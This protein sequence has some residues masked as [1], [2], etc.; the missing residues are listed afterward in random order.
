MATDSYDLVV[1]GGGVVGASLAYHAVAGGAR[2]LL[3]D[4]ADPGQASAAGAGIV[5]A[6]THRPEA[7]AWRDLARAATGYYPELIDALGGGEVTGF[8]LSAFRVDRPGL[9]TSSG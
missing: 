1:V 3:V 7:P 2:T 6:D 9:A 5:S 4:R 8:D